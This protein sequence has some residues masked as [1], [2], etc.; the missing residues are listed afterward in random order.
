MWREGVADMCQ[1][2]LSFASCLADFFST[3]D[4]ASE[5]TDPPLPSF[6]QFT[7]S[8][9]ETAQYFDLLKVQ[10]RRD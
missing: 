1:A 9:R 6:S 4:V 5:P 10:V 8:F 2:Q 7:S 3:A